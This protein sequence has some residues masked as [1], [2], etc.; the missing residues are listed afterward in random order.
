M[1]SK[2]YCT[3]KEGI[4]KFYLGLIGPFTEYK[5]S[6][7][8]IF[9][10]PL[11]PC[12]RRRPFLKFRPCHSGH[13]EKQLGGVGEGGSDAAFLTDFQQDLSF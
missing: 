3:V 6:L 11:G 1:H 7:G 2:K 5:F 12:K 10:C 13:G 9:V 4:Q 8:T